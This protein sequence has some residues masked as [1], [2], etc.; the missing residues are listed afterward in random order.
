MEERLEND[1]V[2]KIDVMSMVRDVLRQWWA[3]LLIAIGVGMI[4]DI[5]VNEMYV[6]EYTTSTT[7]IVTAKGMNT[8]IYQNLNTAVEMSNQFAEILDSN[9]L[10][11]RV[12]QDVGVSDLSF[13]SSISQV[14]ETNLLTLTVTSDTP[15]ESYLVLRSIMQNYATVTDY[16]M[17]DVIIT[18]LKQ[19][20]VPVGSSS[21]LNENG[22]IKKAFLITV[23]VL[24]VLLAFISYIRDTVKNPR[25][26]ENKLDTRLLGTVVH[27]QKQKI[28]T[29]GRKKKYSSMLIQNPLRSFKY[30]ESNKM[31]ASRV[32]SYMDKEKARVVLFT[33][34]M[35]NEGKSTVAA[36]FAISLAK[37]GSSVLLIDCDFRKPAQYK[38]FNL[39]DNESADLGDVLTGKAEPDKPIIRNYND[40]GLFLILNKTTSNS[41]ETLLRS[42]TLKEIIEFGRE[43]MDYV[44]IDTSPL[45]LVADTE[46]LAQMTDASVLVVR[47][48]IVL[49]KDIND[50]IDILNNTKGKVL[51]CILND[52][53]SQVYG[54]TAVRSSA[55][56]SSHGYG[57]EYGSK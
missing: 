23:G 25:D 40:S 49:T 28:M 14:E 43:N 37:G 56:G 5:V 26:A 12:A 33:S 45:A 19:P 17:K 22:A 34:V 8:N 38:L 21:Y 53:S 3:I 7:F 15:A 46:E 24:V 57:G 29:L 47:E 55:S 50:A 30:V 4:T 39:R 51:G 44:V 6:P 1:F 42:S 36:N 27:E 11:K 16:V 48:D 9:V 32:R 35:E 31:V 10:K 41:I 52:A 20:T 2:Q 13:E 54:G 18:T